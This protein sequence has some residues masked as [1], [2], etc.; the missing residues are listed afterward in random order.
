VPAPT[1]AYQWTRNGTAIV[2]ATA[3]SYTLVAADAGAKVGITVTASAEGSLDGTAS[4]ATVDVRKLGSSTSATA[5]TLVKRAT[6]VT[7]GVTVRGDQGLVASGEVR[8]YD[9]TRHVATGVLGAD[10]R[11]SVVVPGLSRG[12][13]LLTVQYTGNGQLTGSTSLPRL[14]LVY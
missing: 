13:H 5:P 2:G 14:L 10:G 9:G 4:S 6:P 8:V 7:V 12:I 3:A 1:L 11:V